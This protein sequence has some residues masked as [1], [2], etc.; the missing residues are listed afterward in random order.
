[1]DYKNGKIYKLW[2]LD[3]D[4]VYY[5]STTQPLHKRLYEHK[6]KKNECTSKELFKISDNVNIE[7]VENY[8]CNN[9]QE[10]GAREGYYIR[11][12]KCVNKNITGRTRKEWTEDHRE[13]IDKQNREYREKTKE[14]RIEYN[15]NWYQQHKDREEFRNKKIAA[16]EA[17]KEKAQQVY[18]CECG[19]NIKRYEKSRHLKS[20][21]HKEYMSNKTN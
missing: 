9:R 13:Y 12:N 21:K 16:R 8:P 11:N 14:H 17:S 10:L 6:M 7:L 1:M 2:C 19:S 15:K 3:N 20:N 4:L 18:H 5:G